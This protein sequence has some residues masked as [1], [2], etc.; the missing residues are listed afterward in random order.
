VRTS[1]L[2]TN[3]E[4]ITPNLRKNGRLSVDSQHPE[5]EEKNKWD[6]WTCRIAPS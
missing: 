6:R 4:N 5:G 1:K 2:T 3:R